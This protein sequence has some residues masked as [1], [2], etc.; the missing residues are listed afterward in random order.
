MLLFKFFCA[1]RTLGRGGGV[2]HRFFFFATT[3]FNINPVCITWMVR[4][5]KVNLSTAPSL[6]IAKMQNW[7][8]TK[9]ICLLGK[10]I[11]GMTI[12][13]NIRFTSRLTSEHPKTQSSSSVCLQDA[14]KPCHGMNPLRLVLKMMRSF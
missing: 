14:A 10:R 3:N 7:G 4:F 1:A 6:P 11:N 5:A 9:W 2:S 13:P 8:L 12:G